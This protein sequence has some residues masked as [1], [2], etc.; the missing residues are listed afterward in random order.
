MVVHL[1]CVYFRHNLSIFNNRGFGA[2][3]NDGVRPIPTGF[4]NN[5]FFIL[6]KS[7]DYRKPKD[8]CRKK[9]AIRVF[10]PYDGLVCIL[11]LRMGLRKFNCLLF[12]GRIPS[13]TLPQ[14]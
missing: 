5:V 9:A 14:M 11:M 7:Y 1:N 4:G 13:N 3:K 10:S 6:H 8:N 2:P 12:T